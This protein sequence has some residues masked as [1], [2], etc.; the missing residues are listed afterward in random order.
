M[1]KENNNPCGCNCNISEDVDSSKRDFI[2]RAT[3]I[4]VIGGTAFILEACGGGGGSPTGPEDNNDGDN[5]GG[6]GGGDNGG[7][8]GGGDNG[9]GS[10]G[11]TGYNYDPATGTITID[12]SKIHTTLQIVGSGIMLASN[13][14]FD[15]RGIIV[16]RTSGNS[17]KALSRRCTHQGQTVNIDAANNNLLCPSHDS[18]FD[19]NGNV[20][21]GPA[22]SS[23]AQYSASINGNII[24]ITSS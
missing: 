15:D 8:S 12:I 4:T 9:G 7:G 23:L 13:I 14:T 20:I 11:D 16:L 5:G 17:V 19:F 6:S 22:S 18:V 10:G 24:T 1:S 21:S 3:A 2:K